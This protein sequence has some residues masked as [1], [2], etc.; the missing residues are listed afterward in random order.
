MFRL[1]FRQKK[2]LLQVK[3]ITYFIIDR[4]TNISLVLMDTYDRILPTFI[5]QVFLTRTLSHLIRFTIRYYY[6]RSLVLHDRHLLAKSE[7]AVK[8]FLKNY[9]TIS[10]WAYDFTSQKKPIFGAIIINGIIVSRGRTD[11][12]CID[13]KILKKIESEPLKSS[14]LK[15][16]GFQLYVPFEALE[17][18]QVIACFADGTFTPLQLL[19]R[20]SKPSPLEI[21]DPK[22]QKSYE[23]CSTAEGSV[24]NN[25]NHI[26]TDIAKILSLVGESS[27]ALKVLNTVS[28]L[29]PADEIKKL[30]LSY[31]E[32]GDI[33]TAKRIA[34][35]YEQTNKPANDLIKICRVLTLSKP[36]INPNSS[37]YQTISIKPAYPFHMTLPKVFPNRMENLPRK[38]MNIPEEKIYHLQNAEIYLNSI[39][40]HDKYYFDYEPAAKPYHDFVAGIYSSLKGTSFDMHHA[41][42][43]GNFE[44]RETIDAAILLAGRCDTNYFHWIIEYLS[45][46][47]TINKLPELQNLPLIVSKDIPASSKQALRLLAPKRQVIF[48]DRKTKL[49]VKELY[50]PSLHTFIPDTT[51]YEFWLGSSFSYEHL[52]YMRDTIY[53][54]ITLPKP[55]RKIYLR[56]NSSHRN[57]KNIKEIET[58]LVNYGFEIINPEKLN[59]IEQVELYSSAK[60]LVGIAGAAFT[61][62]L[63][64]QP[65]CTVIGLIADVLEDYCMYSNIA[66]FVGA[67]LICVSGPADID[68]HTLLDP[69]RG[70]HSSCI[71]DSKKLESAI[72][73]LL[74][75][76]T[77]QNNFSLLSSEVSAINHWSK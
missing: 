37:W 13:S 30:C 70:M 47:Y 54:Y 3:Q 19:N 56:R 48:N 10:G 15:R 55:T 52:K 17:N 58:C 33:N 67:D 2:K 1:K 43:K 20:P 50:L 18:L 51:E 14:L 57:V 29:N 73:Y 8:I 25:T 64:C 5:K 46:L 6:L 61:N 44:R 26:L 71:I 60:I 4:C 76:Q 77:G 63:F 22:N 36:E 39:V 38:V 65:E 34:N 49:H 69:I 62:L 27:T 74:L 41:I 28:M 12:D 7:K 66:K 31:L 35:N 24:F 23:L 75:R 72:Q 42:L 32:A 16:N 11:Q 59:F 45:R 9:N 68:F 53:Q 40:T 21:I